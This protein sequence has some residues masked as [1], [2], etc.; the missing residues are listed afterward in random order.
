MKNSINNKLEKFS[1]WLLFGFITSSIVLFS[2]GD[3]IY[4][5]FDFKPHTIH[6]HKSPKKIIKSLRDINV[7]ITNIHPLHGRTLPDLFIITKNKGIIQTPPTEVELHEIKNIS[8][9]QPEKATPF[10]LKPP[11]NLRIK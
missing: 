6:T 4:M 3:P 2:P 8:E 5:N 10:Q 7:N 1:G 11:T 9:E